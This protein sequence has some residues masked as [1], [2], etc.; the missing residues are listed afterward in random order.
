MHA[1]RPLVLA[2]CWEF[3]RLIIRCFPKSILSR[4]KQFLML[5]EGHW[6]W[7]APPTRTPVCHIPRWITMAISL[8]ASSAGRLLALLRFLSSQGLWLYREKCTSAGH[9]HMAWHQLPVHFYSLVLKAPQYPQHQAP[10]LQTFIWHK[11]I[12]WQGSGKLPWWAS[13]RVLAWYTWGPGFNPDTDWGFASS[14]LSR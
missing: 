4:T 6:E 13:G 9:Q 14:L 5:K 10:C 12:R 3:S 11:E 8:S 7:P 2:G 1:H